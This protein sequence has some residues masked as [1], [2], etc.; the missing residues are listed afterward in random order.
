METTADYP[1]S[2]FSDFD[3][4]DLLTTLLRNTESISNRLVKLEDKMT[5][6]ESDRE[7]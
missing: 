5:R 1:Q 7:S 2:S 3:V 6:I 4:R